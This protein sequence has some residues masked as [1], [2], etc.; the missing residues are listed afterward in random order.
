MAVLRRV[1]E[2]LLDV[3]EVL[4]MATSENREVHGYEIMRLT[5]RLGPTVY[6]VLDK[7][8]EMGWIEGRCEQR[9]LAYPGKPPRQ[10]Y[11]LTPEGL[12]DGKQLLNVRR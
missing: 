9:N 10:F 12:L 7:L 5:K 11:R 1:T 2:P 8:E 3:L 4:V 6:G